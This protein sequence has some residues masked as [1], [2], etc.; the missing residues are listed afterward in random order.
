[1]RTSSEGRDADFSTDGG[2][3]DEATTFPFPFTLIGTP[4]EG[5]RPATLHE[6]R[7]EDNAPRSMQWKLKRPW[8]SKRPP[9]VRELQLSPMPTAFFEWMPISVTRTWC[10][11]LDTLAFSVRLAEIL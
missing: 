7:R 4:R 6:L 10:L 2:G 11:A 8:G 9:L 5:R 3:S 1:M